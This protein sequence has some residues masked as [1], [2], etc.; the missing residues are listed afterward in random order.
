MAVPV[1]LIEKT[2]VT[3]TKIRKQKLG[4]RELNAR[5]RNLPKTLTIVRYT[6]ILLTTI[7]NSFIPKITFLTE[8]VTISK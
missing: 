4:N 8:N 1:I 2:S 6:G 5:F 7:P 3:D